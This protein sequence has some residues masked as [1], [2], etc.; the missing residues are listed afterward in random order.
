MEKI[1]VINPGSTSTKIAVYNDETSQF[2]TKIKH[3]PG[4]IAKYENIADQ[5]EMR[6][7]LILNTLKEKNIN[8]KKIN[9]IVSRGGLLL[10]AQGGATRVNQDVVNALKN[11]PHSH[12]A[13]NL[14]SM[15]AL[16]IAD[17]LGIPAYIYD[18]VTV[19]EL[20]PIARVTGFPEIQ[21]IGIGHNLNMRAIAQLYAKSINKPY[22]A[23]NL[24]IAH[25]GSGVTVSLHENGRMV[26]IVAD[27]EG[28]FSPERSGGAPVTKLGKLVIENKFNDKQFMQKIK[29]NCGFQA[30]FGTMD[31]REI[32][33]RIASGDENAALV[34]EAFAYNVS[35]SIGQLAP[36]VSG[37]IDAIL[38]TGGIAY[39]QKI[40]NWINQRVQFIAPVVLFPGENEMEALAFG[41]LRVM[42]GEEEAHIYVEN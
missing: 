8:I 30:Y 15:I 25:L 17:P 3:D 4:V 13:S 32:E 20:K 35:K 18:P 19:D 28:S 10:G 37:K 39:S 16:A 22:T 38:L 24:I 7:D 12:H 40:V 5:F 11:K 34:Y 29:R 14:G 23:L 42:R 41:A 36:V 27:D 1:L 6:K 26:D 21:R 31:V 33:D 2:V 9:A